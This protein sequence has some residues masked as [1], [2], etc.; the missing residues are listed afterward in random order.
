MAQRVAYVVTRSP[1]EAEDA[2]QNGFI[3]AYLALD[4]HRPGTP[5]RPWLLR[6]VAN[7]AK[8]LRRSAGRRARLE[9]HAPPPGEQRSAEADAVA[10][11][12]REA[13]LAALE[14]LP[15]KLRLAVACRHLAGLTEA[16]TAVV[17][18]CPPGT[19]KSRVSRGLDRLRSSLADLVAEG[20]SV[21]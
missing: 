19:V 2:A 14:R 8:N 1:A 15:E 21:D 3:K 11:H 5:F 9:L 17:L 12:D 16:E 10:G 4:R 18:D 20:G 6:I 13:L 7:E